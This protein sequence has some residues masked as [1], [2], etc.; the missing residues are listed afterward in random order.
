[1]NL[2]RFIQKKPFII[3]GPC[4]AESE[5]QLLQIAEEIKDKTDVFRAGIWKPRTNPNSFE[6]VGEKGLQWLQNV[7]HLTGL[8]TMTEVATAR[9]VELCLKAEIDMFWI[10]A[11]TTVNPFYVQEIAEALRGVNIPIFIKNPIHPEIALWAGALERLYNVGIT[12]LAA[13]HRGFFTYESSVFRNEPKWEI[14]I[15]LKRN[16][17]ELPI[18][19]DPSHIAGDSSFIFELSQIAMD[20]DMNGLMV[21]THQ[22]PKDALSDSRQQ[23]KPKELQEILNNLILRKR[24]FEDNQLNNELNKMRGWIDELDEQIVELLHSRTDLVMNIADFKLKNNIT[25]FQLER[26]YNI[27]KLRKQQ[28]NEIG[29]D[30]K[31]ITDLFEVI[32]KYSIITQTKIMKN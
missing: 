29:I 27:L 13:I 23:I 21:E 18:I 31:M 4:S 22:S 2:E 24:R 28:A 30:D 32:H 14:P 20:L 19:C 6:G 10:G 5:F 11:R 8:K 17:P 12:K 16:Y 1:M 25:I 9:H 7:H 3:A 26:W 15:E